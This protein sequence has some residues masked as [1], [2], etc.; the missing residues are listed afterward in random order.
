MG[1]EKKPTGRL[2]AYG[3]PWKMVLRNNNEQTDITELD[4]ARQFCY[5][6]VFGVEHCTPHN[7][8]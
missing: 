6:D 3:S 7:I 4:K 8:L 5:V 1:E 2:P